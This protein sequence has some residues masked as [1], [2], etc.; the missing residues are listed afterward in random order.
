MFLANVRY[1]SACGQSAFQSMTVI[2]RISARCTSLSRGTKWI[3]CVPSRWANSSI[4][5]RSLSTLR[6]LQI[7]PPKPHATRLGELA[8]PL[9]DVVGRVHGH[10]LAGADDVDLL[11]LALAN[12]HGEAAADDVAEH[13]VEDVVEA[14]ILVVGTELLEHV[15]G[16]DDAAAG[17]ADARFGPAR[18][19]A[20]TFAESAAADVF[21]L[22]V[23]AFFANRVE[24]RSLCQAV[25]QQ[26]GRVGLWDRSRR[27]SPS[28]PSP[29]KR[30]PCF[31]SWWT[32]RFHPCRRSR[33][34]A[35]RSSCLFV[36]KRKMWLLLF[37]RAEQSCV[38]Q[39]QAM[40]QK[41]AAMH[42][43]EE[44]HKYQST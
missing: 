35:S 10:H 24:D 39:S 36:P 3:I 31:E 44:N 13:V 43:N 40:C 2:L 27:P 28:C 21:Q 11:G 22:D 42:L 23:L 30:P 12:R 38:S 18:L 29:P 15:D 16:S 25:E 41:N 1:S 8:N 34:Y 14:F 19:D 20:Q 6:L 9:A 33:P 4:I 32:C 17:T 7:S 26:A 5:S 37:R